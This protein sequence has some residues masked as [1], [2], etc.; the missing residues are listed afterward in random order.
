ML[1]PTGNGPEPHHC[2]YCEGYRIPKIVT[3]AISRREIDVVPPPEHVYLA[4][5]A[6]RSFDKPNRRIQRSPR[7][8]LHFVSGSSMRSVA[9]YPDQSR[10]LD[11]LQQNPLRHERRGMMRAA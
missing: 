9:V 1:L 3:I 8:A 10:S 5:S 6:A 2:R 11:P 4:W 7:P